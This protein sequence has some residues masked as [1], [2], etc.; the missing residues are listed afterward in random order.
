MKHRAFLFDLDG[1]LYNRDT[2]VRQLIEEQYR[3]FRAELAHV[4]AHAYV[5]RMIELDA[6]GYHPKEQLYGQ[7]ARQ[8]N[9]SPAVQNRLL[10]HFRDS[11]DAYCEAPEDTLTTLQTLR[12]RGVRLGIV[13][14]GR[15]DRQNR[16]IAA[17]GIRDYFD[18]VLI[19]ESEGLQKPHPD[20]FL[21]AVKRCGVSADQAVFVGDHPI[22]D[23]D[24]ARDAGLAAIW[25]KVPY[26]SM[27]RA[28][29]PV[30]D[31]LTE[32]LGC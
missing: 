30:V 10:A 31:Q 14:N 6:H 13:T 22:A 20:I 5:D 11:F 27:T 7:I 16:K 32:I 19:S 2:L 29:V 21:R 12:Q 4:D 17:F 8:W 23:I 3:E 18:E 1:T 25:K 15:T 24:G 28:D 26:W 9:L